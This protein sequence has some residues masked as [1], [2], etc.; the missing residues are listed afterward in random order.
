VAL[1]CEA[2]VEFLTSDDARFTATALLTPTYSIG[3][4]GT[5]A[6]LELVQ[7]DVN[8]GPTAGGPIDSDA[9]LAIRA[10]L[11]TRLQAAYPSGRLPL[12]DVPILQADAACADTQVNLEGIWVYDDSDPLG[13]GELFFGI[14]VD[15]PEHLY[16]QYRVDSGTSVG[17]GRQLRARLAG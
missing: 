8:L 3:C 10:E 9:E 13:P 7:V 14:G 15:G 4:D 1:D 17:I 11:V 16:G 2:S 6:F 12:F 5:A